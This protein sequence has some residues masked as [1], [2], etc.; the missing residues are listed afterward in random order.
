MEGASTL[1]MQL[2]R[3]LWLDT[4]KRWKRKLAELMITTIVEQRLSKKEIFEMYANQI[5]LG[6]SGTFSIHGFGAAARTFFGKDLNDLTLPE[7]AL[8]AGLAQR[9]SYF[10]PLRFPERSKTR[11]N[12]V[13]TLM[14]ENGYITQAEYETARA[15][16]VILSDP[17]R[18]QVLSND[19]PHYF[20]DLVS[21]ELQARAGDE[22]RFRNVYTTIDLGL[23]R[24]AEQAVATGM[25]GVDKLLRKKKG[26]KA[27]VAMVVLDPR[28]GEVKAVVG[29]RNYI[30]SQLNRALAR[31]QPGSVFKPFVYAAALNAGARGGRVL[32]P[33]TAV[34]DA[35]TKFTFGKVIYEPGNFKDSYAG[36]VTFRRAMAK[37]LNIATIKAAEMA[38]YG[39]VVAIARAAGLNEHIQPTPAVA[40]GAYEATPL[41]MAGAYT[42]F[43][44]GGTAIRPTFISAIRDAEG[45]LVH[46][47]T[48][49]TRPVLSPAVNFLM[50]S[51]L[52]EVVLSGTAAAVR[53][54]GFAIP[55]A[56]KTGTSRD[57]WFAGFTSELLAVVWVGFDNNDE[58]GLEGSKSALPIWTEF[59]KRA[60][61]LGYGGKEFK[62][63]AGVTS[64]NICADS[65]MAPGDMCPVRSEHFLRGTAPDEVCT[66][67]SY[68]ASD[69]YEMPRRTA[70]DGWRPVSDYPAA[71]RTSS[72]YEIPRRSP[73]VRDLTRPPIPRS[74]R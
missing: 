13:L 43:A 56:G 36:T 26:N 53:S 31:R 39:N 20:I 45:T 28:T 33:A 25:A 32:T 60:Q 71:R 19:A 3:S 24:A 7:A 52:R 58:L 37:S 8:L 49:E 74:T 34:E 30:D 29:G 63:P 59:M 27:Q 65:G 5:Y 57:G 4:D 38:G 1:S 18:K 70:L 69:Y 46:T 67:H 51:M 22:D 14:L 62:A 54:R 11:R 50:V 42:T 9:P 72:G 40:L 10:N 61:S 35:P 12:V 55:A 17:K 47:H 16:P 15:A 44:N 73:E 41:E 64:A 48:P 66:Y 6:H 2:A 21:R 68:Y 23:Q